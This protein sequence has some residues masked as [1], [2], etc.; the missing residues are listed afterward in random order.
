M[1]SSPLNSIEKII[2]KVLIHADISY[3]ELTLVSN[4]AEHYRREKERIR[5]KSSEKG[6]NERGGLIEHG[7]K[8]GI[9]EIIK[10]NERINNNRKSQVQIHYN[11]MFFYCLKFKTNTE[12]KIIYRK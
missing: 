8:T 1:D 9:D 10:Q 4:E 12:N 2:S 6:G 5:T 11:T 3:E 7:N